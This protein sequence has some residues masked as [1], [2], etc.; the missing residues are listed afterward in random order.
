V[1]YRHA[2]TVREVDET[3]PDLRVL[4]A[5]ASLLALLAV[6][7]L[8]A[9]FLIVELRND[10][11]RL[12]G[13]QVGYVEAIHDAALHAKGMANDE[14]GF[15][16]SG[17]QQFLDQLEN[18]TVEARAEFD[19][20]TR[21]ATGPGQ[22]LAVEEARIGFERW[23]QALRAEIAL[24]KSGERERAIAT[25][26]GRT[27]ALRKDYERA[28]ALADVLGVGAVQTATTSVSDTSSRSVTIL[29]VYLGC[30]LAIGGAIAL[31]VIR[32]VLR[33]A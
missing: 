28:L 31:W 4:L 32:T 10:T 3:P 12:T 27:R 1:E 7:V 26:L 9:V 33:P 16:I 29:L 20:A 5:I 15:L 19:V 22:H 8:A 6:A 2:S 11:N 21:T 30:A 14:R 18:R 24:Y 23:L 25:S 13:R 17:R